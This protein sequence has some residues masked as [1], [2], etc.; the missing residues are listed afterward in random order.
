VAV[1][2]IEGGVPTRDTNV[3]ILFDDEAIYVSARMWDHP[4]SITRVMNRRD[5]GGPFFDW[6]GVYFDPNL[7]R[8]NGYSFP[9][10]RRGRAAGRLHQPTTRSRIRVERRSG[11][12]RS[13]SIRWAGPP[14]CVFRSPSSATIA[15]TAGHR[16]GAS[17]STA[18]GSRPVKPAISR[19]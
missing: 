4:D 13:I 3:R 5:E 10:E 2:P 1:E 8:R 15:G 18:V 6:L 17:T 16:R 19:S 14:R 9:R 12:P 7:T 11:N